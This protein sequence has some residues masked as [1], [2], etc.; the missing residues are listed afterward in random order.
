MRAP[1]EAE[2]VQL[3]EDGLARH[4]IDRALLLCAWARPDIAPERIAR[5]PVGAINGHLL[6]L[7]AALFGPGL[8]LQATCAHCGETLEM[9]LS[10]SDLLAGQAEPDEAGEVTVD[11]FRFRLP[12]SVDLASVAGE[13]DPEAA[14]AS[15]L[16]GCCVAR[17]ADAPLTPAL[18]AEADALLEAADPLG[19]L[20][21]SVTCAA[22]G[23]ATE[24]PLDPGNLLWDDIRAHARA[25][26]AQVHALAGAYG[27]AEADVL[28]LSPRRRAAYLELL[29][30]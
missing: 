7:R 16:D 10:V 2:L 19:D 20:N 22:C 5:L 23:G 6:K 9:P 17:P 11:G 27:W 1:S 15:L 29:G 30:A 24:V 12:A 25:L 21:L 3:W 18:R 26:L 14:A 13:R 8:A 4:P 28:A